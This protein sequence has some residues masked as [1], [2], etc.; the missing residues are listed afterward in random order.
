MKQE[1]IEGN[2]FGKAYSKETSP[3]ILMREISG[4]RA[5]GG[6]AVNGRKGKEKMRGWSITGLKTRKKR[7]SCHNEKS[8]AFQGKASNKGQCCFLELFAGQDKYHSPGNGNELDSWERPF[9]G[10]NC[11]SRVGTVLGEQCQSGRRQS[12]SRSEDVNVGR[13]G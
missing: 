12:H 7:G 1:R 9:L 5:E 3:V 6:R 11:W 10:R 2:L 13:L 8:C 4:G